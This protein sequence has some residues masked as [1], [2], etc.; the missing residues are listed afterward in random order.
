M[1]MLFFILTQNG[2]GCTSL[3]IISDRVLGTGAAH[4]QFSAMSATMDEL[5]Q[6]CSASRLM[7]RS[8]S[9]CRWPPSREG[10]IE[11]GIRGQQITSDPASVHGEMHIDNA[12]GETGD[13]LAI[14][15]TGLISWRRRSL[16]DSIARPSQ[17]LRL[18]D[19][20]WP[21]FAELGS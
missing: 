20:L 10:R 14:L 18:P 19:W 8:M 12:A 3:M 13:A 17:E 7:A 15:S 11:M 2:I 5:S 16:S 6:F 9:S 21:I 4:L 1:A